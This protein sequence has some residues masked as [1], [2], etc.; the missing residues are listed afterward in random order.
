MKYSFQ[1]ENRD[2]DVEISG[3]ATFYSET[4]LKIDGDHYEVSIDD[5]DKQEIK[6]FRVNQRFYHVEL[7]T[8]PE[9]FPKGVY[10]NGEYYSAS[11]LKID[12]L[13]HYR[14]KPLTLPRKG[15]VRSFIPG[16]IR[17]IYYK[18]EDPV[19]KGDIILIHEAMK[20]ENEIKAPRSGVI[21]IMGVKEGE[22]IPANRVLFEIH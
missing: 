9:G 13:F 3:N 4:G 14:E 7:E 21:K 15:V 5:Y 16:S 22:N 12:S 2:F 8:G 10:I 11:L 20:M 18:P 1:L 17:K 6:S 19:K